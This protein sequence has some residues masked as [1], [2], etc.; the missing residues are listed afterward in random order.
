M[1]VKAALIGLLMCTFSL[2]GCFSDEIMPEVIIEASIPDGVFV[3][4]GQGLPVNEEPLPLK[5][6]FSDVAVSYTHLTLP[7]IE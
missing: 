6:S 5:F 2:A 3:T 4:N 1:R 7:T